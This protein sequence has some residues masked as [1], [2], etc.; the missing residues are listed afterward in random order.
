MYNQQRF[1]YTIDMTSIKIGYGRVSTADQNLDAQKD[2]LEKAGAAMIF[3]E[4]A[5]GTKRQ[6]PQLDLALSHLRAGDQLL[7][8]RL[9]RLARSAKDLFEISALLDEGNIELCVLEQNIDTS[10]PEGRLFFTLVAGFAEFEHS[11]MAA[12]TR[13]GLAS[14]R[15][16]GRLG[17]RRQKLSSDQIVKMRRLVEL[18]DMPISEIASLFGISRG[19]VYNYLSK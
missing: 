5:S 15:A 11:M 3:M 10:T 9:D 2:A 12:R 1:M 7:V 6:R 19:T 13:E 14:A 4:N 8:T 17:G 18:G 16:R